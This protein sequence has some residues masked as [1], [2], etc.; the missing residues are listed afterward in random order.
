MRG[1]ILWGGIVF[2]AC[3]TTWAAADSDTVITLE[4]IEVKAAKPLQPDVVSPSVENRLTDNP[5]VTLIRRGPSAP[6]PVVRGSSWNDALVTLDGARVQCACTDHMDPLTSYMGG[7]TLAGIVV[8]AGSSALASGTPTLGN[9]N[10]RLL[11]PQPGPQQVKWD[12]NSQV[13]SID[14]GISGD[15]KV[16]WTS[17]RFAA[18]LAASGKRIGDYAEPGDEVIPWSGVRAANLFSAVTAQVS[19]N[20]RLRGTVLYDKFW[21]AGY[22]ALPMDVKFSELVHGAVGIDRFWQNGTSLDAQVYGNRTSHAMDDS[23]RADTGMQMDMP[24]QGSTIGGLM[25][26]RTFAAS[27]DLGIRFES[28]YGTQAASMTMYTAGNAPSMYLETWPNTGTF[29]MNGSLSDEVRLTDKWRVNGTLLLENRLIDLYSE[30]GREQ[31]EMLQPGAPVK[32]DF[33]NPGLQAGIRFV[34]S[35]DHEISFSVSAAERVPAMDELYGYHLFNAVTNWDYIGNPQLEPEDIYQADLSGKIYAGQFSAT[36]TIWSTFKNNLIDAA[37]A[38]GIAPVTSGAYGT[39]RWGNQGSELR[40]GIESDIRFKPS[41]TIEFGSIARYMYGKA[42][43]TDN[44]PQIPSSGGT[45]L[46][47][48]HFKCVNVSPELE[49]APTQNRLDPTYTVTKSAGYAVPNLRFS[50]QVPGLAHVQWR[51]GIENIFNQE[52]RTNQDWDD[53]DT[54]APLYRPGRNFYL[55]ITIQG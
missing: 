9:V 1:L 33:P 31:V 51:A 14:S 30:T 15:G 16:T 25:L 39:R 34:P 26:L 23:H 53:F 20:T 4:Q 10:L 2:S 40:T 38:P 44:D 41:A 24:G 18:T 32:R 49:W 37:A 3:T 21:D 29:G 48:V 47:E 35:V 11:Q 45:A 27:H 7:N 54:K 55:G 22:P 17:P 13:S 12:V 8:N 19:Q 6:E 43:F 52:W 5:S 42:F 28:W 46:A 36:G 50:G